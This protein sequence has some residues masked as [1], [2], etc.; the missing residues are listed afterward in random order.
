MKFLN[1][2]STVAVLVGLVIVG[3]TLQTA[4][5]TEVEFSGKIVNAQDIKLYIAE[6]KQKSGFL[7]PDLADRKPESTGRTTERP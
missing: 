4:L 3:Q 1:I 6:K 7:G 5:A 2:F